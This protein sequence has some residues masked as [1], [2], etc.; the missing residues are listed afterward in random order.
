[1]GEPRKLDPYN[2][3]T[4]IFEDGQLIRQ[5]K[6]LE[7]VERI[8]EVMQRELQEEAHTYEIFRFVLKKATEELD[9]KKIAL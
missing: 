9:M 3:T 8:F 1:M 6:T 7:V 2:N 4:W 5:S